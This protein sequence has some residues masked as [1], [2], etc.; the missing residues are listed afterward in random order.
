MSAINSSQLQINEAR[1]QVITISS[2]AA[3]RIKELLAKREKPSLGIK[4]GI[5]TGGCSG[6][7]YYIEYADVKGD[8]DEVIID[9]GVTVLVDQKAILYLVGTTMDYI[10]GKFNSGFEFSNPNEKN[11]CGCGKSASF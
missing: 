2:R 5:K 7:S 1:K 11:R 9:K 6:Y 10:E 8:F 4:V 3:T